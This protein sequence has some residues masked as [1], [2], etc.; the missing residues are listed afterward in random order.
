MGGT[1][2]FELGAREIE[3]RDG[4]EIRAVGEFA[5]Q[6]GGANVGAVLKTEEVIGESF[7]GN[8]YREFARLDGG[9]AHHECV[10]ARERFRDEA[11]E[12]HDDFFAHVAFCAGSGTSFTND[13]MGRGGETKRACFAA[14]SLRC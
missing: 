3:V 1:V 14:G 10:F 9:L 7:V 5:A 8:G 13:E 4:R 6:L 2:I 11:D 12:L